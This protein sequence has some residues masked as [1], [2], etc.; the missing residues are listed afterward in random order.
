M[1]EL[2]VTLIQRILRTHAEEDEIK[3]DRKEIYGEAA[4]HGVDKAALGLAVRTI[5]QREKSETPAAA[6]RQTIADLYI[7]AFDASHVRACAREGR[8]ETAGSTVRLSGNAALTSPVVRAPETDHVES[9][10]SA[11]PH[12]AQGEPAI[13]SKAGDAGT[14]QA[15]AKATGTTEQPSGAEAGSAVRT[16]APIIAKPYDPGPIPAFLDRRVR[17]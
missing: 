13:P 9:S 7:E 16:G 3:S 11:R 8:N 17:A 10:A 2:V 15:S 4:S 1:S 12:S 5:R 6:E 14:G